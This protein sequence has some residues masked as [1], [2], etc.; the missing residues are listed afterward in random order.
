MPYIKAELLKKKKISINN[1]DHDVEI[2]K[3]E[4]AKAYLSYSTDITHQEATSTLKLL[5]NLPSM[6]RDKQTLNEPANND[7]DFRFKKMVATARKVSGPY[8]VRGS[9]KH[10][11]Q[12]VILS[13]G[14]AHYE[15]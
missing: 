2:S 6:Q 8:V 11:A 10:R 7:P 13:N 14:H 1:Y 4:E 12:Q 15:E 5:L 3:Q 9:H